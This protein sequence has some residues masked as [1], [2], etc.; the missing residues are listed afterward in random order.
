M[1]DASFWGTGEVVFSAPTAVTAT[2]DGNGP[3]LSAV[4]TSAA[5][6]VEP[7][8]GPTSLT[9]VM[10][11]R[12]PFTVPKGRQLIGYVQDITFGIQRSPDVRVLIMADLAGTVKTVEFNFGDLATDQDGRSSN[13]RVFS[14]QGLESSGSGLLGLDGPVADYTATIS[15]TIQRRNL[16]ALGGVHIDGLDVAAVLTNPPAASP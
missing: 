12:A 7:D 2:F 16:K 5:L 13:V 11:F 6:R 1:S 4:V 10:S 3:I 14:P 9:Q 8:T 15:I